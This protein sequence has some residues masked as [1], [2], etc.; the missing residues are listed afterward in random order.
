[1]RDDLIRYEQSGSKLARRAH[2]WISAQETG[3]YCSGFR[4]AAEVETFKKT[5]SRV[6]RQGAE[7][8]SDLS[9]KTYG[10]RLKN[11]SYYDRQPLIPEI[12]FSSQVYR[13]DM[14]PSSSRD[15]DTS[16]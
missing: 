4:P 6:R 14:S 2:L 5:Y 11:F 7:A 12:N 10:H 13:V 3:G 15:V 16:H 8:A 1:M 9:R